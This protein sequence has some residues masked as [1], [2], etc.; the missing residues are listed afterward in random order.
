VFT[1]QGPG[2]NPRPFPLLT[3]S[4]VVVI[5]FDTPPACIIRDLRLWGQEESD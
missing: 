3:P 4:V 2:P 5:G 1:P